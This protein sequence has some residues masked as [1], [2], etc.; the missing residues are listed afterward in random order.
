M[1]DLIQEFSKEDIMVCE[2]KVVMVDARGN[3]EMGLDAKGIYRDAISCFWQ[4]FYNTCTLGERERVPALRHDFQLNDMYYT[5]SFD[6]RRKSLIKLHGPPA[7]R[8]CMYTLQ[9]KYVHNFIQI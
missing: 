3:D 4:E 2:I 6:L 1:H 5:Q 9:F 8:T 7:G